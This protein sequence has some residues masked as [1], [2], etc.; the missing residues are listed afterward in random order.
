MIPN[1]SFKPSPRRYG[2]DLKA[3]QGG[4]I[5]SGASPMRKFALLLTSL[6]FSP[7]LMACDISLIGTWQSDAAETMAFNRVKAKL[8]ERQDHF[9]D[10]LMGRMTLEFTD[11]ELHL[12]MP[13]TLVSVK[14]ELKPFS[15]F[16][17]RNPYKVLFCN[18]RMAV[19]ETAEAVTGASS[20]TTYFFVGSNSMWAYVGTNSPKVPDLHIREYFKRVK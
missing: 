5:N 9:L 20:V 13:D 14:G 10:S 12:R 1:N 19:I 6:S 16:E 7:A 2:Y 8:E 17:E 3:D 4:R 11:K 15:G 18:D